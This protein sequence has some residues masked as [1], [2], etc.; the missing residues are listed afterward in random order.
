M[1]K[2]TVY[3]PEPSPEYDSSNQRQQLEAGFG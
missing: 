3:I 2:V 1:A